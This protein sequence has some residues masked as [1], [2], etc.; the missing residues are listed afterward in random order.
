MKGL[1]PALSVLVALLSAAS[2]LALTEQEQAQFAD[3]LYVRGIYDMALKE[4]MGFLDAYPQSAL[5]D[6]V[7]F[8]AGECY[9]ELGNR[10]A[11]DRAYAKVQAMPESPHRF[12]AAFRRAEL[13]ADGG[14]WQGAVDAFAALLAQAPPPDI[15]A[16]AIYQ[17][18]L[19]LQKL[20]R[21]A[22]ALPQFEKLAAEHPGS[23]FYAYALM[24]LAD[25][26][27]G[28]SNQ[29]ARAEELY[30]KVAENPP[31]NRLG[32]EAWFR[33]GD[34]YFRR[35]DYARSA[36]AYEQ[37]QTRYPGD[38]RAADARLPA[39]WAFHNA[40]RHADAIR[41]CEEAARQEGLP[42][43]Q[44]AGWL[45]LTANCESQLLRHE[46]AAASY[47]TLLQQFPESAYA[48]AATY[49]RALA[50]YKAGRYEEAVAQAR[51]IK[52]GPD[53]SERVYWLLAES[54][55]ALKQEDEAIQYY[56]LVSAEF[57]A[58]SLAPEAMYRLAHLLRKRGEFGP[59]A[60]LYGQVFRKHPGAP[61][62]AQALFASGFCLAKAGREDE[63]VREWGLL[64][65]SFAADPLVE[66]ALYQKAIT[67]A[68]LDRQEQ[69]LASFSDLL[70]RFPA[71]KY[72][73]DAR[74]WSGVMLEGAG[75]LGDAEEALRAALAAGPGP[76]LA[77]K[78]Q[79]RLGI[80]LH[81][82]GKKDEAAALL[83][84]LLDSPLRPELSP[85]LVEWLAEHQ[86]ARKEY[87]LADAAAAALVE[88][89]KDD[90]AWRQI[91][92]ALRGNSLLG[93]GKADEGREQ[94]LAAVALGARTPAEAGA[95]LRLGDLALEAGRLD[96]AEAQYSRAA[97]L[98][99]GD[100]LL[101]I[102][103]AAYA[104]LGKTLET[105]G[106]LEGASRFHMSVALLFDNPDVVP[107]SLY[108][109]ASVFRRLGREGD[110]RKALQELQARYPQ[111]PW[112]AKALPETAAAVKPE[113]P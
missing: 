93:Q 59:A 29:S 111:S 72:A 65:Q 21:S 23:P 17:T 1:T 24:A 46:A 28:Q 14:D 55:A 112:A 89:G 44:R 5:V 76:E 100:A 66:D 57:P 113:V 10:I 107:E 51:L 98:S 12:R 102:R 108:R 63:A 39:A 3:G 109:A 90:T 80:V 58:S 101:G 13:L 106:D 9:R 19:G 67:E 105:R 96:E 68:H 49:E 69:S 75:K 30:L 103:V 97:D 31:T 94:L 6:A 53:L 41:L 88:N 2:A 64:V 11:A 73:A 37:L 40:G 104:G 52:P 91:G 20:G 38:I 47:A 43:D 62:A 84:G 16:G 50:L 8:R 78:A 99:A 110:A 42:P 85:E 36:H 92:L 71:T 86:L 27:A 45:Y 74:Y 25:A 87:A 7:W 35:A 83:Q 77:R 33:L 34:L 95:C 61:V 60:E 54:Y 4:Y 56:Q 82:G 79:L 15:A 81:K 22:E 32:A 18:G 26:C 70:K 48:A